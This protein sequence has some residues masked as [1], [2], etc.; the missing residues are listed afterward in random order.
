MKNKTHNR[1]LS[2]LFLTADKYPPFRVDLAV[3]FGEE[4]ACRGHKID[5]LMQ[6]D[7]TCKKAYQTVWYN[8]HVWV[9]A[10]DNGSKRI[11]RLRK[12]TYYILHSLKIFG[13]LREKNYDFIQVK[14]KVIVSLIAYLAAKYFKKKI[15]FWLSYPFPE[16]SIIA[17][18]EGTG[19][20]RYFYYFRG[21]LF[22]LLLYKIIMPRFDHI[23]VQ[24]EQMKNDI[25]NK[26]INEKNITPVPMGF[27]PN[28]FLS[29]PKEKA[30][31]GKIIGQ[32]VVY[33]G[34]LIR[35][36]KLE[37]LIYVF[38]NVLKEC[39]DA[40]L[41]LIGKGND[42]SDVIYLKNIAEWNGIGSSIIFTGFLKREK[43]FEII[44][45]SNVC[46][47]PFYPTPILNSTS[48]T[49]LI[50]YM[51]LGKAVIANDHPEQSL[52]IKRSGGGLC[53]RYNKNDFAESIIYL[54]KNPLV[55]KEM[56]KK[57]QEYVYRE[58]CYSK[59]ADGLELKYMEITSRN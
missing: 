35:Q 26:K 43:A 51:A 44:R 34:T 38:K 23:F 18:K 14:D 16:A 28:S 4:L 45:G 48:P 27:S 41:Y 20:Y 59:I 9:G 42:P 29:Y 33:L 25:I 5:L 21:L 53:V 12:H 52:I 2:F 7:D 56:G 54:L 55:A 50:E 1:K 47:S 15:F 58:R 3:L 39:P 8:S 10:T 22:Q 49:K 19:R 30:I 57:G 24:S 40:M 46:V 11:N 32:K 17:A 6:S 13:L 36:R 37:F 31:M